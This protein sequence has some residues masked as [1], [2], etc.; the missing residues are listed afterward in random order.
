[1]N[2]AYW[3]RAALPTTGSVAPGDDAGAQHGAARHPPLPRDQQ[4]RQRRHEQGGLEREQTE[5]HPAIQGRPAESPAQAPKNPAE[6]IAETW[7][8]ITVNQSAGEAAATAGT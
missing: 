4:K 8:C 1:M 5:R 7:P 3:V 2:V 6:A